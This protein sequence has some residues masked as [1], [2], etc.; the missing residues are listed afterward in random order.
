VE[1]DIASSRLSPVN[2]RRAMKSEIHKEPDE[3]GGDWGRGGNEGGRR[4]GRAVRVRV[5]SGSGN[6]G[7]AEAQAAARIAI[8][9]GERGSG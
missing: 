4:G 5:S 8:N 7:T 9:T 6:A 3:S 1:G 2:R